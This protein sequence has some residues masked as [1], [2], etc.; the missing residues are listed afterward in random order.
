MQ[1][2]IMDHSFQPTKFILTPFNYFEW[3]TEITL[4]LQSKGLFRVTMGIK[5]EPTSAANKIKYFK[6]LDEDIVLIFLSISRDLLFHVSS[7]TT[8]DEVWTTLEVLFGQQDELQAHTLENE[9]ISLSPTHF[10]N[11]Q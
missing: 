11:I 6:T 7:A 5:I 2:D 1:Q 8:P 9:I 3:K 4:I 10:S